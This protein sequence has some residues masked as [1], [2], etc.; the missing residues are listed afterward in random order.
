MPE[1]AVTSEKIKNG[2]VGSTH[3]IRDAVAKVTGSLRYTADMKLPHM[4]YGKILFS[5]IAHGKIRSIDVSA[6]EALPGVRAVVCYKDAP[7]VRYNSN[8]EDKND[9]PSEMV[10]ENVV[11][12]VGDKVAAVAADTLQ[13]A[14]KAV[15]LIKVEYEELPFYLDPE[16]AMQE[17]AYPIHENGNVLQEVNLSSGDVEEAFTHAYRVYERRFV[18]P[19]VHHSALE[20]HAC[21]ADYSVDGKLTV[22]TP[23]QDV[24]GQRENL[25]RIFGLSMNRIRVINPAMGGGFGGK[26]DLIGEPVAALLSMKTLRPVKI[27]YT[28]TE[29]IPSSRTRHAMIVYNKIGV[30]KTGFITAL[31]I[32]AV[33][34]AGAQMSCTMS[35]TW[36]MGG[37]VFKNL[38][39]PNVRFRGIPVY[40]NKTPAGAMRGFGSPQAFVGEQCMIN[41]I[42][43]D[44]GISV[45]EMQMKN[46]VEPYDRDPGNGSSHGNARVRDALKKGM[47]LMDYEQAL[48]EQE[49]SRRAG[50]RYRIGVGISCGAHG[51]GLHGI[52][53]DTTGVM[54]KLNED[55]SATLMTGVSDMGNGSVTTQILVASE[56]LGIP[57]ERFACVQA[58]TESTLFDLGAYAS[59]GSY[60]SAGAAL[61]VAKEVRAILAEEAGKLLEV[62]PDELEFANETVFCREDAARKATIA[63]VVQYA[64]SETQRDIC[65]ADTFASFD[66]PMSYGAHLA[67]VQVDLETGEVKPLKYVSVHDIG[68][69]LN[70]GNLEGQ[71]QGGVQMGL[72][73]ALTEEILRDEKGKVKNPNFRRY[74][75]F[76]AAE[77]PEVKVAMIEETENTGPFGAKS[78]GECAVV[79]SPGAVVNAISNA[80][81][82]KFLEL[83]VTPERIRKALEG[84]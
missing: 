30:D 80:T 55:G 49:A 62:P 1:S 43:K 52:M 3:P 76:N 83:P 28:R 47:E 26:I 6:A 32:K 51:N 42:A 33:V 53:P 15:R 56:I 54:I 61:K 65:A 20:P 37:K 18:L 14:E 34:D 79:P 73:Y 67:K 9:F 12:Y 46:L 17:G 19:A 13:I 8:G 29:D 58:D 75:I 77:I 45:A 69:A 44:L 41:T 11:R 4:L 10:F 7:Q 60:V 50:G 40:T 38:K 31:D 24:F 2:V 59:R 23:T 27:V 63:Q 82:C 66:S 70:P 25:R 71:M 36:A 35:V 22:Y 64:M 81:D 84:R 5:P 72:G 68:K 16:D 21:I 74:H 39:T 78:I 48:E 57:A